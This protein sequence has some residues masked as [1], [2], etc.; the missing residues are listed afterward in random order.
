MSTLFVGIGNTLRGDDGIA[1]RVLELVSASHPPGVELRCVH[2]LLPELSAD[3]S[4]F[5][6]V[7]FVDA[8]VSV[9][10]VS[11]AQVDEGERAALHAYSP[12]TI[13]G[14]SRQLGFRGEAYVCRL[15][16]WSLGAG[17]GLSPDAAHLAELAAQT[18]LLQFT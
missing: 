10:H 8:D 17:E 9:Q 3:V 13:V 6:R 12:S 11:L 7:I 4:P 16:V 18:L 1:A 5:E 14:Y 15:P 2:S